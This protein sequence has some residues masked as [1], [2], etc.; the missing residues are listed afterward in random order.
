MGMAIYAEDEAGAPPVRTALELRCD[1]EHHGL[2][3]DYRLFPQVFLQ[4]DY[5][6]NHSA[7]MRAGWLERQ[8][9][10][11]RLWLCPNCS[12]KLPEKKQ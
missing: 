9:N 10:G 6:A 8:G 11:G 3:E 7:A 1:G 4:G 5:V 12:G 2:F